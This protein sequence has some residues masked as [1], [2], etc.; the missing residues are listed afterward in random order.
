MVGSDLIVLRFVL[1][2]LL[3][4]TYESVNPSFINHTRTSKDQN[5]T[6]INF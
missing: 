6:P 1:H 4:S 5:A 2:I 3:L